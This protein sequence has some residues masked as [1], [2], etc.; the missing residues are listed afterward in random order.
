MRHEVII[1]IRQPWMIGQSSNHLGVIGSVGYALHP[2]VKAHPKIHE[3]CEVGLLTI[4]DA[5]EFARK[6]RSFWIERPE[7]I[8][9]NQ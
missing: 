7:V 5:D 9:A 6:V 1:G 3:G 8:E 2:A 4:N